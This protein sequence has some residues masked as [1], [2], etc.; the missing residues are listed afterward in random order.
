MF[1]FKIQLS[2]VLALLCAGLTGCSL[3][4][5]EGQTVVEG[6]VVDSRTGQ[7]VGPAQVQV[8]HNKRGGFSSAYSSTGE[9][10]DT[11]AQGHFAFSF[12]AD[13]EQNYILMA[14][15]TRGNSQ[16]IGAPELKGG[17]KNKDVQVKVDSPAWLRVHLRDVP[18]R[19]DAINIGVGGFFDSVTLRP[20][21]AQDTAF[22]RQVLP[23]FPN[24]VVWQLGGG[25]TADQSEHRISYTVAPLDT[26]VIEVRYQLEKYSFSK[27]DYPLIRKRSD[28][29]KEPLGSLE[30]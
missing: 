28:E 14:R 23:D 9:W 2:L 1:M 17:R 22:V 21:D 24:V 30:Q 7:A 3:F 29:Q 15:S 18:P 27:V 4:D 25:R 20:E 8:M 10:L 12:D 16:Y 26:A 13:D 11:D 19:T 6:Q 5:Y